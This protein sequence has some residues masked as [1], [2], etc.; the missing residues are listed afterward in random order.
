MGGLL[1][2]L[3]HVWCVCGCLGLLLRLWWSAWGAGGEVVS[4]IRI[5]QARAEDFLRTVPDSSV[6]M[7]L[8]DPPYFRVKPVGW[9][10]A[11]SSASGFL[12]WLDTIAEQWQRVLAPNGTLVCFAGCNPAVAPGASL[13][14][15]VEVLLAERFNVV[16]SAV[17]AKPSG[18]HLGHDRGG[19]RAPAPQTERAIICEHYGADN[20][21][22]GEAGYVAKCDE[23]RGFVFEPLRAYLDGEREAA[24]FTPRQVNEGLGN[25]MAG[26]YFT[27]SQWTLPTEPNYDAMRALFNGAGGV[28]LRRE[29]EDLRREYEDL[30]REYEDLRREYEDLRRPFDATEGTHHTDVWTYPPVQ[31]YRGK[32]P[33]EKPREMALD[34]VRQCS[35]PGDVVLD[36][37]CGSGVFLAAAAELG[38]VAIGCDADERWANVAR[39]AVAEPL[40][41][42][43]G[44]FGETP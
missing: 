25:Q 17:W 31:A 9:D 15:R 36:T 21:A 40:P 20:M 28:H 23:L 30:R 1:G 43:P 16:A 2:T 41:V 26:H 11:W 3:R 29:Y 4:E 8:T 22:K 6:G 38:R 33:C 5:E 19:L 27:R 32:H 37:F 35:R 12:D 42:Q 13:A 39:R 14:A 34:L 10:R 24:G 44:L 7:V 18:R